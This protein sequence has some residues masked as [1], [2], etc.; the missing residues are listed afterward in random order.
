MN[1]CGFLSQYILFI[2]SLTFYLLENNMTPGP[3]LQLALDLQ[4][5]DP[6]GWNEL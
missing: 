2:Y 3:C 1:T 5:Q 6:Q 4:N